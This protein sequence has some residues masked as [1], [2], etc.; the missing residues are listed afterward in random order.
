VGGSILPVNLDYYPPPT[1]STEV[2]IRFFTGA[3]SL[4]D[5][6]GEADIE[7]GVRYL[8]VCRFREGNL[9]AADLPVHALVQVSFVGQRLNPAQVDRL[10]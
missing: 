4:T 8:I 6:R 2:D 10:K 1:L 9:P 7:D 5:L 3:Q